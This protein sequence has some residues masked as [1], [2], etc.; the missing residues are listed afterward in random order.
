MEMEMEMEMKVFL[1]DIDAPGIRL[2]AVNM[3]I[4]CHN[5]RNA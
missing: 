3:V 2:V 5:E 1:G 4:A